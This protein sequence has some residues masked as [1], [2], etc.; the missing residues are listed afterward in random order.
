MKQY[1]AT[2]S[3]PSIS[4]LNLKDKKAPDIHSLMT[5]WSSA[6]FEQADAPLLRFVMVSLPKGWNGVY[7]CI[8]HRIMDSLG[9]IF[10]MN[11]TFGLYCHYLYGTPMP[12]MPAGYEQVLQSDLKL[13]QDLMC[14]ERDRAFWKQLLAA[15]EPVYTDI[16]GPQTLK[17]SRIRHNSPK[18]R[19]ADRILQPMDGGLERFTLP[20]KDTAPIQA[21]CKKH[22][23]SLTNL[24]LMSMR[25]AL[26][27][28]N[29][30]EPDISI[31]NYVSRRSSRQSRTCGGCRIH[32][33]PC[34]TVIAPDT[35]FLDGIRQIASYQNN[36]YRHSNFDP[37]ALD[38][39]FA[40]AFELPPHTTYEGAALTCQPLPLS[41]SN[42]F[43][44]HIPLK[45]EWFSSGADIQK[46]YLTVMQAP[47][48]HG[49]DFHFKYQKAELEKADI[50]RFYV[51]LT[52]ILSVG[53]QNDA[54]T[55]REIWHKL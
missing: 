55:I 7:L 52:K 50:A 28:Q 53:V 18:L 4:Y 41:L 16:N 17:Q 36:I 37:S 6:G 23:V 51:L 2:H 46:L 15:G 5:A 14:Q 40:N 30:G 54:I 22:S 26:S 29:A 43:L 33:Y 10:M 45:I 38:E 44:K 13:E 49:L 25:T 35:I 31:R 39:L 32:C 12:N 9:L 19:A 21:Y 48:D 24:L 8:D 3:S 11:D 47:Q 1:I 20:K 34:R 27:F 42:P